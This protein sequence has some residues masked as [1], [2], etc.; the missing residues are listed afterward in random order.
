MDI[1]GGRQAGKTAADNY[2]I[3]FATA[4]QGRINFFFFKTGGFKPEVVQEILIQTRGDQSLTFDKSGSKIFHVWDVDPEFQR[5]L[6]AL[7]LL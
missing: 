2:D 4:S 7:I 1:L 5:Y 6:M 3:R